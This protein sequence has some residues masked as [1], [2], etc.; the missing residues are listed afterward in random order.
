MMEDNYGE[1]IQMQILDFAT[2]KRTEW[3]ENHKL[4]SVVF[5][6]TPRCNFNCVHCYLHDHHC[7]KELSF[8]EI[9]RILD[10]LYQS[11][12][13]FLTLTGGDVFM[14]RDFVDIYTYA[15]KKGFIVELYTNAALLDER[16]LSVLKKYP[17]LLVDI[18]L[19]G[20]CEET[21]QRVTGVTGAF[22]K[23]LKNIGLLVE[24]NIRVSLKAPILKLYY[25]ELDAMKQIA[26][27]YNLPFRTGLEI[28]PALENDKSVQQYAVSMRDS[29]RYEFREY[30]ERPRSLD[31]EGNFKKVNLLE[32]R[33][34]FRCKLGQ[35]SCVIDYE[36]RMCPCM[37]FRQ[38]G[39]K[40]TFDNFH[41][42]WNSFS[43]YPKMKASPTYK[44]LDCEAYDFCDICPAKMDS[45]H[46]SLEFVDSHFCKSAKA[47]YKY[48]VEGC[49]ENEVLEEIQDN[50]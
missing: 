13:L 15:K 35:A 9:I 14:R 44:C 38:V 41:E 45:E 1:Q 32:E 2:T 48:Y 36:G 34:L 23:V 22:E 37:S 42:V 12:V 43:T 50:W 39:R 27:Q 6:I 10:I 25:S 3:E 16:T 33:P 17:P 11:G 4:Y 47:R 31:N 40:L 29:L 18:S 19:Y 21:Y 46:G 5:E 26:E 30:D 28:F 49:P 8:D 20:S 24:A 7:S